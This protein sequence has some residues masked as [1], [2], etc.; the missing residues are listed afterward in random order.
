MFRF[1]N[2]SQTPKKSSIENIE[3]EQTEVLRKKEMENIE[4]GKTTTSESNIPSG[5]SASLSSTFRFT[6]PS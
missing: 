4:G 2:K 3:D 6:I 1:S 5:D